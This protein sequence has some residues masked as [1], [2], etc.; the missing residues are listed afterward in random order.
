M[1]CH[2]EGRSDEES[3][4]DGGTTKADF[5]FADPESTNIAHSAREIL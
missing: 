5:H 4:V 3:A 2:S 1:T